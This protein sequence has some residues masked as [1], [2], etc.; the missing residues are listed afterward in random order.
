MTIAP[1]AIILLWHNATGN[2]TISLKTKEKEKD[3]ESGDDEES[4][5]KLA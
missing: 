2:A 1:G 4:S 5:D 3:T